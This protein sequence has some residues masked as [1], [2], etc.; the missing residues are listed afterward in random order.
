MRLIQANVDNHRVIAAL[1]AALGTGGPTGALGEWAPPGYSI[2]LGPL[3][4]AID[5]TMRLGCHTPEARAGLVSAV[6]ARR[7]R[8][9]LVNEDWPFLAKVRTHTLGPPARVS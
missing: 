4:A 7:L 3:E 8:L 6:I 1:G 2:A 9:G 5:L